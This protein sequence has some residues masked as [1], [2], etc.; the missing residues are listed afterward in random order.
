MQ[1]QPDGRPRVPSNWPSPR[2]RR[3]HAT[4]QLKP[5][6]RRLPS[7][8]VRQ[9]QNPFRRSTEPPASPNPACRAKPPPPFHP[10]SFP[11]PLRSPTV[12]LRR[13]WMQHRRR[14][15]LP[16]VP[17][18]AGPRPPL[19]QARSLAAPGVALRPRPPP[20]AGDLATGEV[21][22][23]PG[24]HCFDSVLFRVPNVSFQGP[25]CKDRFRVTTPT[26]ENH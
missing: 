23:A 8:F 24:L 3:T 20:P 21:Q 19:A 4:S 16:P 15:R 2:P 17:L 22:S 18:P 1:P 6:H 5:R 25:G 13:A 7:L 9:Q 11:R 10:C 12:A 14:H 26:S